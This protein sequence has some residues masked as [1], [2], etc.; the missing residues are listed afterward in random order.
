VTGTGDG[1]PGAAP[2]PDVAPAPS[3]QTDGA[4]LPGAAGTLIVG[5]G[6]ALRSDDGLGL[7][8]A[9]L[10]AEDP[11]LRGAEVRWQHQLTPEL[12]LDFSRASL[13][14]LIDVS[15]DDPAGAVAVKRLDPDTAE[16]QSWSHHFEP[17]SLL[18]LARELWGEA[19]DAFVVSV[20]A[21]SLEVGDSLSPALEDALPAVVEAVVSVVAEHGRSAT[22]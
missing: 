22:H 5:Y 2:M 3:E 12:A 11:R 20:G 17:A 8:A 19:P 9:E 14:I 10:L 15:V 13:V 18:G 1:E 7:R 4:P 16:G 21:A 6:N